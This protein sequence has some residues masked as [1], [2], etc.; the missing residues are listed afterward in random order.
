MA[1]V[2]DLQQSALIL[3]QLINRSS[4]TLA[5]LQAVAWFDPQALQNVQLEP[6]Y[7]DSDEDLLSMSICR[8]L[9]PDVYGQINRLRLQGHSNKQQA[10]YL[11]D[12][13]NQHL[14]N[15]LRYLS[16]ITGGVPIAWLGIDRR[17][18]QNYADC[19]C[20]RSIYQRFGITISSDDDDHNPW[21]EAQKIA[22]L[23]SNSLNEHATD[24][25]QGLAALLG[26]LF[27]T[28]GNSSVDYDYETADEG[29]TEALEWTADNITQVNEI[30]QEAHLWLKQAEHGSRLFKADASFRRQLSKNIKVI[31]TYLKKEP[32][33]QH[34]PQLKWPADHART[35]ECST[36]P[37]PQVLSVRDH[38]TQNA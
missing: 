7:D 3:S 16:D 28:S 23:L 9:F 2:T 31:K 34:L 11:L 1:T 29:H 36:Q 5:L 26:W 4:T 30:T 22:D 38:L 20:Y 12:G 21:N 27:S 37:D 14:I 33:G 32:Y 25:H 8:S 18:I 17:D 10:T 6:N 24:D 19:A 35:A 15:P 13:I